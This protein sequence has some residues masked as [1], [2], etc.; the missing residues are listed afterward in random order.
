[1]FAKGDGERTFVGERW[2][3][4]VG[5]GN[6]CKG[7]I[8][9]GKFREGN[10]REGNVRAGNVHERMFTKGDGAKGTFARECLQGPTFRATIKLEQWVLVTFL[11]DETGKHQKLAHP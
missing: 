2:Q 5:E 9:E 3:G 11:Q 7:N 10:V 4:N 8:G 6:V 1:M